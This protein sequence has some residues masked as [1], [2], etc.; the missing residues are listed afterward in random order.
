MSEEIDDDDDYEFVQ[1]KSTNV[2]N[3]VNN[4]SQL[5][6]AKAMG[7]TRSQVDSIE[8]MAIRKVKHYLKT[9]KMKREDLL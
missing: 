5:E 1:K 7:I 3:T 9:K 4:M 8:K 6:V 2:K